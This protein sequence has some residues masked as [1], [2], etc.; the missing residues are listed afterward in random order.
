MGSVASCMA[1][2]LPFRRNNGGTLRDPPV[3]STTFSD[4][5]EGGIVNRANNGSYFGTHFLMG[6]ERFDVAKPDTFLFGDNSDLEMLGTKAVPYPYNIRGI[7]HT[8]KVLNLLIN[9]RRDSIKFIRADNG[10]EQCYRLEFILDADT[11]CYVQIH[12]LAREHVETS[13]INFTSKTNHDSSERVY[14]S[15][16]S[17]QVFDKFLFYPHKYSFPFHY[18]GGHYF[19]IVIEVRSVSN[20]EQS[21]PV[22]VQATMCS[23]DKSSD[24]SASLILKPLKQK[25][26]ADGVTYLLQ[27][28]YGIENKE[29]TT[30][31]IDE[32]SAECIICMA[33]PRDTVILPCRHLCI[34]NG[35]AETLRF[36]LQN[37]PICRSPFKA[38]FKFTPS[39]GE[40]GSNQQ[41]RLTLVEALNGP[42]T[43]GNGSPQPTKREASIKI[44]TRKE[45]IAKMSVPVAHSNSVVE[46]EL[47]PI[48]SDSTEASS[49]SFSMGSRLS[50]T[51]HATVVRVDSNSVQ[52]ISKKNSLEANDN[53]KNT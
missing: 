36:K 34:C 4:I 21:L 11:D 3:P 50:G 35:C 47:Q 24:A 15:Q 42:V 14:F 39:S 37:C 7:A 17:D 29:S 44:K 20:T 52:R 49:A 51:P 53:S 41:S 13:H 25:I 32:N 28:V 1:R 2:I 30:R 16:G 46:I 22:H 26:I 5:E 9:V 31:T 18:D 8:V 38:L 23:I 12:F 10:E 45:K 48:N 19:P 27:E 40:N 33:N 6:G 43:S